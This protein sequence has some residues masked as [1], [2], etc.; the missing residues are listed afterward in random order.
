MEIANQIRPLSPAEALARLSVVSLIQL[1][2]FGATL[3]LIWAGPKWFDA[4]SVAPWQLDCLKIALGFGLVT[5]V[6][7]LVTLTVGFLS[8][9]ARLPETIIWVVFGINTIFFVLGMARTGGPAHSFFTQLVPIQLSGILVL[10]QQKAMLTNARLITWPFAV[11]SIVAWFAGMAFSVQFKKL[12]S[13]E[14]LSMNPS[15]ERFAVFATTS[16]FALSMAVTVFAY[17]APLR[18]EFI[19]L[20]Q[21]FRSRFRE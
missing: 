3:L 14:E 15:L 7:L 4:D 9:N 5:V 11:F 17:W 8:W 18:P 19:S 12:F 2:G 21:R 6:T 10:E 1:I 13:W 20:I 16:L